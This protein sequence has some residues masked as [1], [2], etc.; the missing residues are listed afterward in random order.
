[1]I[2][3]LI[4]LLKPS[5]YFL[6]DPRR[7]W[8]LL[9]VTIIA[10]LVDRVIANTTF[11]WCVGRGPTGSEKTVSDM[12]ESLVL[13]TNHPD[14]LLFIQIALK[15]NRVDPKHSHIKGVLAP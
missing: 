6:S 4:L 9:P 15:I 11:R 10:Y 13:D 5:L 1:M 3:L 8:Y 7:Y 2:D 12:L 14:Q